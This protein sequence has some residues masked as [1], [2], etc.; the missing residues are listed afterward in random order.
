MKIAMDIALGRYPSFIYGKEGGLNEIPI[1][2]FHSSAPESL[3]AML[4]YLKANEYQTLT[5]EEHYDLRVNDRIHQVKNPV[6]LTFGNVA[7]R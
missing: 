4:Q 6:M 2:C 1:F 5:A 3:E 7:K